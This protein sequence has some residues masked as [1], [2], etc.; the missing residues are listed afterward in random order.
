MTIEVT[1]TNTCDIC[2]CQQTARGAEGHVP[3]A[4]WTEATL[5]RRLDGEGWTNNNHLI[6]TLCPKCTTKIAVALEEPDF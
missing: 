5:M 4:G 2:G 6:K 3:A 1:T